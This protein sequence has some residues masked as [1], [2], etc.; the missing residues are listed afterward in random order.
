M[1]S[2]MF[3]ADALW[4]NQAADHDAGSRAPVSTSLTASNELGHRPSSEALD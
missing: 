2:N 3:V 4:L 1:D